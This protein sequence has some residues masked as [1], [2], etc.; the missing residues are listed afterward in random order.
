MNKN[1]EFIR[2]IE[3]QEDTAPV[4]KKEKPPEY[5]KFSAAQKKALANAH[6]G[7]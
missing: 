3:K 1:N 2:A 6:G 5:K 7:G 4:M